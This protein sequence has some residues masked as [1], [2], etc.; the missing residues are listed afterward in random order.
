MRN[1]QIISTGWH[2]IAG[3]AH[4]RNCIAA[5]QNQDLSDTILFIT[6]EPC[7]TYGRTPPCSS[8]NVNNI[9]RVVIGTLDPN[10]AHAGKGVKYLE[11]RV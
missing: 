10:K 8:Y 6:L 4:E 2:K 9:K 1:N 7:S 5:V 11:M 3:G